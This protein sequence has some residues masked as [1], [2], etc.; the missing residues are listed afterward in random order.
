MTNNSIW[1]AVE[2]NASARIMERRWRQLCARYLPRAPKDS[3]WCYR[4]RLDRRLPESGWKLH[5]SATILNAPAVLKK[6]A[7]FLIG[8]GV[9]F[10]AARTL[11]DI[12]KLNSGLYHGYSQIGKVITVYPQNEAE[13]IHLAAHLHKLTRRFTAPS[14]PFDLRFAA[15]SNVYYRFGAFRRVAIDHPEGGRTLGVRK[16]G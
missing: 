4:F 15:S 12:A 10:K 7:P 16:P 1:R 13:A 5:I 9:Q 2:N 11:R 14:V 6:I 3:I 8:R